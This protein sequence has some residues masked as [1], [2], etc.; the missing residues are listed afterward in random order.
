MSK[1]ILLDQVSEEDCPDA[2]ALPVARITLWT[3]RWRS[4]AEDGTVVAVALEKAA[5]NG[6]V[7]LG[8]GRSFR[9]A[10]MPEEVVA[11]TMPEEQSMAAKIG[12]YLG[13]R[14]LPIEVREKEI[15]LESFPT[16][17]DSLERI[18]IGYT[19]R[20]DVLNCRPHSEHTH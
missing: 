15:L 6:N 18:G 2:V 10:Q 1:A 8:G 16:L 13:N 3:R 9:I 5:Q 17:T 7:L 20:E 14:H 11:I 4:T 19:M 12:W